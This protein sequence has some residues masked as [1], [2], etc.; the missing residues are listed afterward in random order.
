MATDK[1]EKPRIPIEI[2]RK[3]IGSLSPAELRALPPEKLPMHIPQDVIEDAPYEMQKILEDLVFS[4][5]AHQMNERMAIESRFGIAA[6][7]AVELS[8]QGGSSTLNRMFKGRIEKLQLLHTRWEASESQEDLR[9][10]ID[11]I[12]QLDDLLPLVREDGASITRSCA[13]LQELIPRSEEFQVTFAEAKQTLVSY[14]HVIDECLGEYFVVRL[15]VMGVELQRTATHVEGM[16]T[17]SEQIDKDVR[18]IQRSIKNI[19]NVQKIPE[20]KIS[21]HPEVQNL[22]N[23]LAELQRQKESTDVLISEKDLIEWLD[24]IV[25]A[26]LS[27][28]GQEKLDGRTK[29]MRMA[30]FQLL[31]RYCKSQED[32][33]R[34][35]AKNPFSQSDP[36]QTIRFMLKS[37]EF[38]LDYFANKRRNLTEW[39]GE[40]AQKKMD[41]LQDI[42]DSML[43]TMKD[44]LD[45]A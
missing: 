21:T 11:N 36:E 7:D 38:V 16:D 29:D 20:N 39:L 15:M 33:A 37:E 17:E 35:V 22:Q 44:Q 5:E 30:L 41:S 34:Q 12:Y 9:S 18:M 43:S 10:L 23:Q 8:R 24:L 31:V 28:T 42:E 1:L 45:T 32:A 3:M 13:V 6:V 26:S 4:A 25:D 27:P 14:L 40:A 2:F 19:I